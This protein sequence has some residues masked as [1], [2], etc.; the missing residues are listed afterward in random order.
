MEHRWRRLFS[1]AAAVVLAITVMGCSGPSLSRPSTV[2]P[3]SPTAEVAPTPQV[4]TSIMT[5]PLD[6]RT[7][8]PQRATDS[9]GH[10]HHGHSAQESS[11]GQA[12]ASPPVESK[13]A[14]APS[15]TRPTS[16]SVDHRE[17]GS[18]SH[19]DA[20]SPQE[21]SGPKAKPA[22]T[23]PMPKVPPSPSG[24]QHQH[25]QHGGQP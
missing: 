13:P 9:H 7:L 24:H 14:A 23:S 22:P 18:T 6:E 12:P 4:A 10:G 5:D 17:H 15:V 25:H 11:P 3:A 20:G 21:P 8:A 19:T 2:S 16:T 1:V